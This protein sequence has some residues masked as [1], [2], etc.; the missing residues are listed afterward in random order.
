[1]TFALESARKAAAALNARL[2]PIANRPVDINDPNW[3]QKL[4]NAP[5]PLDEA[6][7]R[8]EAQTLMESI[9]EAYSAGAAADRA[10]IREVLRDNSAFAWATGP[11]EPPT[12]SLG[13]RNHLL[14]LSA[15]DQSKDIRDAI[16][17]VDELC[18]KARAAGVKVEPILA[19][20][21]ALSSDHS[22][23]NMGSMKQ[24]LSRAR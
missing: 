5:S 20:V 17:S 7:V 4:Q 14:R 21:A 9:L 15:I 18:K 16:V 2:S 8:K 24:V 3:M 10:A 12:T 19:E 11:S 6:N 1:M 22:P 13:F 23:S